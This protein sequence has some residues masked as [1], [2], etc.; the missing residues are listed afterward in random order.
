MINRVA[1]LFNVEGAG[2]VTK[3]LAC[4]VVCYLCFA[5]G[6]Y[7]GACTSMVCGAAGCGAVSGRGAER[8]AGAGLVRVLST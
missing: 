8:V 1:S 5:C 7:A 3:Q 2:A 6:L 4:I